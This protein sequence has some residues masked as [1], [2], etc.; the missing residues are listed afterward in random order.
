MEKSIDRNIEI[1]TSPT[2]TNKLWGVHT[3]LHTLHILYHPYLHTLYYHSVGLLHLNSLNILVDLY[4]SA[5]FSHY[6]LI[7]VKIISYNYLQLL[8]RWLTIWKKL[9]IRCPCWTFDKIICGVSTRFIICIERI[10]VRNFN[11]I[12]FITTMTR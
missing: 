5:L 11:R 10:R 7:F 12:G 1:K 6:Q 9:T 4:N 2:Q 3:L 8:T